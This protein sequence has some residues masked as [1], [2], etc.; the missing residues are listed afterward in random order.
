MVK[1]RKHK[2]ILF[3][4]CLFLFKWPFFLLLYSLIMFMLFQGLYVGE[5]P[6]IKLFPAKFDGTN[7]IK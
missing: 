1:I 3:F 4:F 5:L 6:Q 2:V 7:K